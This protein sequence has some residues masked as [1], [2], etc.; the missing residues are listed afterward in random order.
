MPA[1][2]ARDNDLKGPESLNANELEDLTHL[3]RWIFKSQEL[4]LKRKDKPASEEVKNLEK[5]VK[6]EQPRLL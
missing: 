3:R 6:V 4:H 2:V 5:E 1:A